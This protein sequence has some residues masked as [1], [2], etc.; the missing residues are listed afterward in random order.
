MVVV[1]F[2]TDNNT[3]LG[4]IRLWQYTLYSVHYSCPESYHTTF[5][6]IVNLR[7]ISHKIVR[8]IRAEGNIT[9]HSVQYSILTKKNM[10]QHSVQYA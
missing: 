5:W 9:L 10:T 6:E 2:L 7:E 4:L 1:V 3:T 8:N